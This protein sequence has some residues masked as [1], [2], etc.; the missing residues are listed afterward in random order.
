[1]AF[2]FCHQY[3]NCLAEGNPHADVFNVSCSVQ[4][5]DFFDSLSDIERCLYLSPGWENLWSNFDE[6]KLKSM[7]AISLHYL[8]F[9]III[10]YYYFILD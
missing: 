6:V 10:C 4:S 9:V 3:N 8:T 7:T 1:M 2:P 5:A